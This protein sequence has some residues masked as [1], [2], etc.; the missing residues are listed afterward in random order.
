MEGLELYLLDA[1]NK[2]TNFETSCFGMWGTV[3][4]EEAG[5]E[6]IMPNFMQNI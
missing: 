1:R 3:L 6:D 2:E 4:D 5:P